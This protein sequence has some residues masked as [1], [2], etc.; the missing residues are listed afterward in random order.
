MSESASLEDFPIA[1]KRVWPWLLLGALVLVAVLAAL[2]LLQKQ[3]DPMR[4]LVV[5]DINGTWWEGSEP[6]AVASDQIAL[7]FEKIGFRPIKSGDPKVT[8]VLENAANLEEAAEELETG[9]VISVTLKPT[10]VEHPVRGTYYEVRAHGP[11]S[12]RYGAEPAQESAPISAWAGASTKERA[13]RTLA[14][15][16]TDRI[17]DAAMPVLMDHQ[18][19]IELKQ[20]S[21]IE[22]A[23]VSLAKAYVEL[24]DKRLGQARQGYEKLAKQRKEHKEPLPVSYHG[25][26]DAVASVCGVSKKG[27]LVRTTGERLF[28]SPT[29]NEL[30]S[31]LE[32]EKLFFQSSDGTR[33]EIFRGYNIYGYPSTDE[34]GDNVVLIEDFFRR[35][36]AISLIRKGKLKR[37]VIDEKRRFADPKVAPDGRAVAVWDR[38]CRGCPA[39]LLVLSLP[40]GK[41][42]FAGVDK[43]SSLGGFDWLGSG[44][45]AFLERPLTPKNSSPDEDGQNENGEEKEP[46]QKL[47][48]LDLK[49][50]SVKTRVLY[51][52]LG[53]ESFSSPAASADGKWLAMTRRGLDG[54]NLALW[55]MEDGELTRHQLKGARRPVLS[56]DGSKIAFE[57]LGN[58]A[59]VDRA[60]LKLRKVTDNAFMEKY[61]AFD[62]SGRRLYFESRGRNPALERRSVSVIAKASLP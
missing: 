27:L 31:I 4:L 22:K 52:A 45:L 5:V 47:L 60:T 30:S 61:P 39:R 14:D 40:D 7:R 50:G 12:V 29:S 1:K 15:S 37:L 2:F 48:V 25:S 51:E 53:K 44:R 38:A 13:L 16:L 8:E 18:K 46:T 23:Q 19:M 6:A 49:S 17:F 24:R 33:R 42:L 3:R 11:V 34:S 56:P 26:F 62:L 28:F 57:Q 35:A 55:S 58:I 43:K 32:L 41:R 10:V 54:L 21:S 9:F 36:K 59:L 20:G